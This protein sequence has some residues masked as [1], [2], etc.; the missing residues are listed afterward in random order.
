MYLIENFFIFY[1]CFVGGRY[2][3]VQY[4][5]KENEKYQI[6]I[7]GVIQKFRVQVDCRI[8]VSEMKLCSNDLIKI[9][10]DVEYCEIVDYRGRF[11]GEYGGY[12]L[13]NI[14]N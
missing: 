8:V 14:I 6:R 4:V 3:F 12:L 13:L 10:V 9:F 1:L 2:N 7:R 5:D 11:I